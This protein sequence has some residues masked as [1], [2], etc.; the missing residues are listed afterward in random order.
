MVGDA[1]G[2]NSLLGGALTTENGL[3]EHARQQRWRVSLQRELSA[4]LGVEVAYAGAYNDKLPVT[5]RQDYLP[6]QYLG[7][8]Q[9]AQYRGEYLPHRERAE[10]VLHQQLRVAPDDRPGALPAP[11]VQSDVLVGDHPA[12]PPAASVRRT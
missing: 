10:S 4:S 7:R 1:L 2:V 6:E 9:R 12:Q 11:G 3:R 5:I 8:Q